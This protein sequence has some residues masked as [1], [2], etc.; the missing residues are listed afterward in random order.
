LGE[1]EAPFFGAPKKEKRE[2]E[3]AERPAS[4]FFTS[5]PTASTFDVLCRAGAC[6][7]F[8]SVARRHAHKDGLYAQVEGGSAPNGGHP[9]V[10]VYGF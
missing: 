6:R 3:K 1:I 5:A 8:Q 2:R 10:L 4:F 9:P 7:L